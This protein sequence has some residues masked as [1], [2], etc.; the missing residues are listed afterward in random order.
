MY[1]KKILIITFSLIFFILATGT[2]LFFPIPFKTGGIIIAFSFFCLSAFALIFVLFSQQKSITA[3]TSEILLVK[4]EYTARFHD[5]PEPETIIPDT[6]SESS[7]EPESPYK[8][9]LDFAQCQAKLSDMMTTIRTLLQ[10]IKIK[11]GSAETTKIESDK[12]ISNM[13]FITENIKKAFDIA[14]NLSTSAKSAFSVSEKVQTGVQAVIAAL[15]D[16]MQFAET[17]HQQS[18]EIHGIVEMLTDISSRINILS[19]NASVVSARAGI[20]GKPFEVVAKEIRKLSQETDKS[21][22]KISEQIGTIT[23]IINDVVEKIK[24]AAAQTDNEKSA[25]FSVVGSLQGIT[26]G[27]EVFRAVSKTAKERSID[28]HNF[29]ENL[30]D[31]SQKVTEAVTQFNS[32]EE[33]IA[34]LTEQLN[35]A[36]SL[37]NN[38]GSAEKQNEGDS[39]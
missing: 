3:L 15:R 20:H 32:L 16:S 25:L 2:F 14:D 7:P 35:T 6:F 10:S 30:I 24:Y 34:E 39:R 29:L 37:A 18:E 1:E 4:S 9:K 31:T 12:F 36:E 28:Q 23:R 27:V 5:S 13:S 21:L 38:S 19:I 22:L 33:N 11:E 26:L 8:L 17:L